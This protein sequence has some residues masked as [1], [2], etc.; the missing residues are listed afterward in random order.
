[1]KRNNKIVNQLSS[2]FHLLHIVAIIGLIVV[3]FMGGINMFKTDE[4]ADFRIG[5]TSEMVNLPTEFT[6]SSGDSFK[7]ECEYVMIP[8]FFKISNWKYK[9]FGE[10]DKVLIMIFTVYLFSLLRE[11]FTSLAL[12]KTEGSYFLLDTY[13]RIKK[14]G[15]LLLAFSVYSFFKSGLFSYLILDKLI[16]EGKVINVS[17]DFSIFSQVLMVLII[18]VIAEVY[19]AGIQLKEDSELTI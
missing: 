14:I 4:F 15:Y 17:A 13:H 19:K 6:L 3:I 12:S 18:F 11:I 2:L 9:L 1:M 10:L 5:L 16:V 8:E 7:G